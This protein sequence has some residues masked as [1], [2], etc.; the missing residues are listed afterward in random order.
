M[1]LAKS[2]IGSLEVECVHY[3]RDGSVKSTERVTKPVKVS[4]DQNGEQRI[5][6]LEV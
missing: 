4:L 5:E 3:A 2:G 1:T 6:L